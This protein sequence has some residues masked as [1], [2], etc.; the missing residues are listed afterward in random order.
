MLISSKEEPP[1][2]GEQLLDELQQALIDISDKGLQEV[3]LCSYHKLS[4]M[5]RPSHLEVLKLG[6]RLLHFSRG[7]LDARAAI[8]LMAQARWEYTRAVNLYLESTDDSDVEV[9][10]DMTRKD[11]T[12]DVSYA[13]DFF[14]FTCV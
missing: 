13:R 9:E 7:R 6:A 8:I 12:S 4:N 2:G 10:V 14:S 3:M 1:G 11:E 5:A